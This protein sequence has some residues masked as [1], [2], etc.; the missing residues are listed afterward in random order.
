MHSLQLVLVLKTKHGPGDITCEQQLGL[1]YGAVALEAF[2]IYIRHVPEFSLTQADS[3]DI[4]YIA[5]GITLIHYEVSQSFVINDTNVNFGTPYFTL[6]LLL[7]V[8]LTIMI[9]IK[10]VLHNRRNKTCHGRPSHSQRLYTI[11]VAMLVESYVLYAA[12][13][14]LFVG[15]WGANTIIVDLFSPVLI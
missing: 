8:I 2:I 3:A 5:I 14:L 9:V 15:S 12:N 11:V 1:C 13:F 4:I 7:T 6:S 10:L